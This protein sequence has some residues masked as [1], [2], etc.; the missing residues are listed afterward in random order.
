MSSYIKPREKHNGCGE[1]NNAKK[2]NARINVLEQEIM[3]AHVYIQL[4]RKTIRYG[5]N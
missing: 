3:A 1:T 4:D 2:W 5:N